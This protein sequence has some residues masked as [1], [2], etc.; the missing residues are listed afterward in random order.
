MGKVV[1]FC[2]RELDRTEKAWDWFK[3]EV[4][5]KCG[6]RIKEFLGVMSIVI[7]IDIDSTVQRSVRDLREMSGRYTG[8]SVLEYNPR[9]YPFRNKYFYVEIPQI[10]DPSSTQGGRTIFI[11]RI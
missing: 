4:T 10:C 6:V 8:Y 3:K 2:V 5:Y 11:C 7:A 1:K 9:L